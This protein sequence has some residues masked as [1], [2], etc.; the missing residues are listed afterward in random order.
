MTAARAPGS[1]RE[2]PFDLLVFDWDGTLLDSVGSI[3]A[4]TRAALAELAL[5]V[6]PEPAIRGAIGLG[7]DE[8]IEVLSPGCDPERAERL[9]ATYGRH[10]VETY[11]GHPLLFTGVPDLLG[12]FEAQGYLL[13]VATGKSRGGLD[14]D[15][16]ATGLGPRFHATRTADDAPSKPHPGMLLDLLDELGAHPDRALMVGD[17]VWDLEMAAA[18]GTP[19]VAVCSG[20]SPRCDLEAREPAACLDGVGDLADWLAAAL[21][22]AQPAPRP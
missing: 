9:R 17:S 3:V 21:A 1:L 14:H 4:C 2:R 20:G 6:P 11:R 22:T 13:A 15:L 7:I 18:A 19:V 10:W 12:R 8:T 5:P 16:A